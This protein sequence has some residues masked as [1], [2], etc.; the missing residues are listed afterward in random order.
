MAWYTCT[1]VSFGGGPDF[2]CRDSGLVCKGLQSLGL[3]CKSIMPLPEHSGDVIDDLIRTDVG[4]LNDTEWWRNIGAEKVILYSWA[5][6]KYKRIAE[7]ARESGA[8]VLV[9]LDGGGIISPKAT[10]VAHLRAVMGRQIR[11]HGPLLGTLLGISSSMA[12]HLSIPI[13]QEP[14]RIAHLQAAKAI[15]CISPGSLVLWR[16]WAQAYAPELVER[17]HVVPNPV[18]ESLKYDP[19]VEK[20][21]SVIAVGR[22]DDE[23]MKRP[24]FLAGAISEVAKRRSTTEFHIYGSPGRML[25]RWHA[26]LPITIRKRVYLHG[27]VF[28]GEIVN[29]FMRSRVG[30]CSSSHEG[31]HVASEEAL[32]AGASIVA[33]LRVELN[34]LL[35]YVSHNSGLLSAEDS[36]RGLAETLLLELEGWDSGKRDPVSISNYWFAILSSS[37]VARK[38]QDLLR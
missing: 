24:A 19:A 25:P 27:K 37:A 31:S 20:Q 35:W 17:M 14:G 9:N 15:G 1:P 11:L 21:D 12:Y 38:I 5:Y 22:W 8:K 23:E 3:S 10:P 28:H 2:F 30:L 32:C 33:P 4:N 16:L 36:A 34:A 6:Y 18:V 7:A 26:E 13:F 29:A